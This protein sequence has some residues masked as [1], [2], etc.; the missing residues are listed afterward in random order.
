MLDRL[1]K[2][3]QRAIYRLDWKNFRPI[4]ERAIKKIIDTSSDVIISAP[5]ASGKTE[6]AF[7]PILSLTAEETAQKMAI[8]Y[9]SPLKALIN[10]QFKRASELCEEMDVTIT[11]WH[12]D[13]SYTK[14]KH[15]LNNPKGILLITPESIEA[16]LIKRENVARAL[17]Q[18]IKFII[19]DELHVFL[20]QERG[21]QLRSLLARIDNLTGCRARRV[22]LSA[23]LGDS[24][25]VVKC[26]LA[27]SNDADIEVISDSDKDKE[28]IYSIQAFNHNSELTDCLFDKLSMA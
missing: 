17:F 15:L 11:K 25:T 1:H 27:G 8:M 2:D 4:Q 12:G 14:K 10:D 24:E 21:E 7:I 5:T 26:W 6:A 16:M 3:V 13:A 19:I 22:C 18:H 23:T 28:K 20:G 9:I